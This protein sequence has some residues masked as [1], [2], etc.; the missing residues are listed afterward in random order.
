VSGSTEVP[1]F[2]WADLGRRTFVALNHAGDGYHFV[3]PVEAGDRRVLDGLV[4]PGLLVCECPG[5]RYRGNC[6]QVGKAE[7]RLRGA[8][9]SAVADWIAPR[10]P[11]P[12][13][14]PVFAMDETI[15]DAPRLR[16]EYEAM[17]LDTP[18]GLEDDLAGAEAEG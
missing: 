5:G 17:L 2:A 15:E 12:G 3:H 9:L 13:P 11:V 18:L 1:G 4:T 10:D 14:A 16:D 6:Y 8:G 7:D